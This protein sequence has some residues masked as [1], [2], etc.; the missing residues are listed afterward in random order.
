MVHDKKTCKFA[1]SKKHT[2]I[3]KVSILTQFFSLFITNGISYT[4]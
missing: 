3:H 4:I 2:K 1:K